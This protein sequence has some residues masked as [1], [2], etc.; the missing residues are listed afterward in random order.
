MVR[1]RNFNYPTSLSRAWRAYLY[2]RRN[3][4]RSFA[5][6]S[7]LQHA[8]RLQSRARR[9]FWAQQAQDRNWHPWCRNSASQLVPQ[10]ACGQAHTGTRSTSLSSNAPHT[11][12]TTSRLS[13]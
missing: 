3:Y 7:H 11:C 2:F 13:G 8:W 5:T 12:A 9:E 4:C 1:T 6:A 10:L